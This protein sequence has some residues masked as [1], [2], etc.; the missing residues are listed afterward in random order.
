M[1]DINNIK[2]EPHFKLNIG[3]AGQKGNGGEGGT[4]LIITEDLSGTGTISSDG[5]DGIMGGKGGKVIIEAK[6]NKYKGKIS[7]TGGKSRQ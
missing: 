3:K 2:L 4:I 7:A 5:G 1:A 6:R